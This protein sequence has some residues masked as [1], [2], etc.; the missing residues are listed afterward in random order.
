MPRLATSKLNPLLLVMLL[1]IIYLYRRSDSNDNVTSSNRYPPLV[2]LPT[3]DEQNLGSHP[4]KGRLPLGEKL[5][6]A[7]KTKNVL[8][9]S[10]PHNRQETLNALQPLLVERPD[11]RFEGYIGG[12]AAREEADRF[13]SKHNRKV[14]EGLV[15]CVFGGTCA[16]YQSKLVILD[17]FIFPHARDLTP[18]RDDYYA[19]SAL[20][21]LDN[22]GASYVFSNVNSTWAVEIHKLFP[23]LV[24]AVIF[25]EG[26]HVYHLKSCFAS[27]DLD[28]VEEEDEEAVISTIEVGCV[29]SRR[30]PQGIPAYKIFGWSNDE[31]PGS[32]L[33]LPWTLVSEPFHG[34]QTYIGFSIEEQCANKI[35][36]SVPAAARPKDPHHRAFIH[37]NLETYFW[38]YHNVWKPSWFDRAVAATNVQ[39]YAALDPQTAR[40]K[41]YESAKGVWVVPKTLVELDRSKMSD[42][43]LLDEMAKASIFVGLWD[44]RDMVQPYV[45]L[46]MGVPYLNPINHHD[47]EHPDDRRAWVAQNTGLKWVDAPYVYNVFKQDE[48]GFQ[49]ALR[50]SIE[51]TFVSYI[52]PSMT[53]AAVRARWAKF[54]D[55]DWLEKAELEAPPAELERFGLAR[56][57]AAHQRDWPPT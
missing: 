50:G 31:F 3:A 52:P 55:T 4:A 32:P 25:Q 7:P 9:E 45:A 30:F 1:G 12:R 57:S 41:Y 43:D 29:K 54:L 15:D 21:S 42:K 36:P 46:C 35:F 34:G 53:T 49:D 51:N 16:H 5:P 37:A 22:L 47:P 11:A 13:I 38:T 6:P 23:S 10:M 39:P 40:L 14:L 24:H 48:A 17:A 33:G 27:S 8:A 20:K 56:R 19:H 18:K 28:K 26:D 44:P 2:K